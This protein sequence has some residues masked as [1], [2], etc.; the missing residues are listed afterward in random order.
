[1]PLIFGNWAIIVEGREGSL[2]LQ[3]VDPSGNISFN[4][5]IPGIGLSGVAVMFKTGYWNESSQAITLAA[6]AYTALVLPPN[7]LGTFLFEGYLFQTPAQP[8]PG[9]DLLWTL[10]GHVTAVGI[11]AGSG[12]TTS[13]RRHRFG[14]RATFSQTL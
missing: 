4:L 10:V 11:P 8:Q 2:D 3:G 6:T 9:Q 1:M 7:F 5:D 13:A 12:L 14:W